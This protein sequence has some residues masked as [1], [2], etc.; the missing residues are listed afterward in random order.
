[1][2]VELNSPSPLDLK[3]ALLVYT[4]SSKEV[5]VTKNEIKEG[6]V[7]PGQP[8]DTNSFIE[9]FAECRPAASGHTN[10]ET[11]FVWANPN[12]LCENS[13]WRVWWTPAQTRK[14]F[15]AGLPKK[16]WLPPLIWC[17]HR[18]QR[19]CFIWAF[20]G[21]KK[22][23]GKT[24]CYRPRFGPERGNHVHIGCDIC[25]GSM[26]PGRGTPDEWTTAFYDTSFK[27]ADGLP[28]KPHAYLKTYKKIG[29][30]ASALAHL[31][32][33]KTSIDED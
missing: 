17:G 9:A 19:T 7:Q 33:R 30:L 13:N 12:L 28:S 22:P 15:I 8:L 29:T 16:C 18:R 11:S 14:L 25:L 31:S 6:Q 23:D 27:T 21:K 26:N 2:E 20:A 1:M 3:Y 4:N 10:E 5:A 24:I 32:S